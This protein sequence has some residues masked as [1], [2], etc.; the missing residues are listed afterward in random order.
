VKRIFKKVKGKISRR[1]RSDTQNIIK[2]N[3]KRLP[4]TPK[5]FLNL[6]LSALHLWK[7][8]QPLNYHP[9]SRVKAMLRRLDTLKNRSCIGYELDINSLT[10]RVLRMTTVPILSTLKRIVSQRARARRLSYQHCVSEPLKQAVGQGR[11]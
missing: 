10:R 8:T 11:Q 3:V 6:T 4:E 2:L 5:Y 9:G 1:R 7:I